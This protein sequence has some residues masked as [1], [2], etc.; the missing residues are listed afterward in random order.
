MTLPRDFA[1]IGPAIRS[2]CGLR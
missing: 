1:G 2:R